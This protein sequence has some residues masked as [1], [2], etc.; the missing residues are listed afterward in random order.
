MTSLSVAVPTRIPANGSSENALHGT[1]FAIKDV[2]ELQG[3]RVTA[4]NRAFY[5]LQRPAE[6]T[7]LSIQKLID[8]GAN[9]VGTTKLGSLIA[10]EEPIESVDYHAAF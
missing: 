7:A 10:R 5:T 6:K 4:G 1:R 9:L 3:L 8:Q 2:F